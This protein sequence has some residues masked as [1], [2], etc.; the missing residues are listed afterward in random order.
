MSKKQKEAEDEELLL[1]KMQ[2]ENFE[3]TIALKDQ[4]L[5]DLRLAYEKEK[6]D[7][8]ELVNQINEHVKNNEKLLFQMKAHITK[9][10]ELKSKYDDLKSKYDAKVIEYDELLKAY[11]VRDFLQIYSIGIATSKFKDY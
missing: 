4:E 9:Y 5:T 10:D 1:L 7:K 6:A 11:K 8:L 2:I 3:E